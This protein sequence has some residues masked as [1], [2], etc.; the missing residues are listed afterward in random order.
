ME[1]TS[2]DEES[3]GSSIPCTLHLVDRTSCERR[4]HPSAIQDGASFLSLPRCIFAARMMARR[5]ISKTL[6]WPVSARSSSVLVL[7]LE[8]LP[9][10]ALI[11]FIDGTGRVSE[12]L[13]CVLES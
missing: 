8:P 12:N 10:A 5:L 9:S 13:D 4:I 6:G 2:V 1:A 11:A 7:S 3:C